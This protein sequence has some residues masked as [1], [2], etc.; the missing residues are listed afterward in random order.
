MPSHAWIE[1]DGLLYPIVER[2]IQLV[3]KIFKDTMD[4]IVHHT[5]LDEDLRLLRLPLDFYEAATVQYAKM[6]PFRTLMGVEGA[7]TYKKGDAVFHLNFED[8][9]VYSQIEG[10]S[11][12]MSCDE[13][14]VA[15]L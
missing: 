5:Y 7:N 4:E 14:E 15:V 8:M 11:H 3:V 13:G 9:T 2:D 10:V 6:Y 1:L 12:E